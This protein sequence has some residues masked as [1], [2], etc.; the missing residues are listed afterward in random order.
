LYCLIHVPVRRL[1]NTGR[2]VLMAQKDPSPTN[3]QKSSS[4]LP[5]FSHV[6]HIG[7]TV[8]DLNGA[9]A[10]YTEVLGG[11]ELYRIGPFDAAQMPRTADRRDWTESHLNLA[12]AR[13]TIAMLQ[14]GPNVMLELIQYDK[15]DNRRTVPPLNADVGAHHITLRVENIDQAISYLRSKGVDLMD[16]PVVVDS[17]PVAGLKWI[18]FLDPWGNTMELYEHG[19]LPFEESVDS[20]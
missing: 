6:E 18:Y 4:G 19:E 2:D 16:G 10:F 12:G 20:R 13:F 9:V 1:W 5:G 17:G 3:P 7:L 11:V 8:P 15:P 14:F